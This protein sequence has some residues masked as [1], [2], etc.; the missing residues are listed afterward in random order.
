MTQTS[1]W[2]II[3]STNK[4]ANS[5]STMITKNNTCKV[6]ESWMTHGPKMLFD[7][8]EDEVTPDV[9]ALADTVTYFASHHHGLDS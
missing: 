4:N 9:L 1:E 2:Y 7:Q 8:H 5:T 3:N 6:R